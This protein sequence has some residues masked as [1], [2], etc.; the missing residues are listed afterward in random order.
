MCGA[1]FLNKFWPVGRGDRSVDIPERVGERRSRLFPRILARSG[2]RLRKWFITQAP[3]VCSMPAWLRMC[4]TWSAS[5]SVPSAQS[6]VMESYKEAGPAARRFEII[7]N[8]EYRG[9]FWQPMGR[10]GPLLSSYLK[11]WFH[12]L[13][14]NGLGLIPGE[15]LE[16]RSTRNTKGLR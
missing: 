16:G 10:R 1:A 7:S 2:S 11:T 3:A 12:R 8:G 13:K 14:G 9:F 15:V 6:T 5:C 4:G